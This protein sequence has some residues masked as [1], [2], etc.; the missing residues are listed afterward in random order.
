[1]D[2][3]PPRRDI[4]TCMKEVWDKNHPNLFELVNKNYTSL[5]HVV[6][7]YSV[8]FNKLNRLKDP[9]NWS[10]PIHQIQDYSKMDNTYSKIERELK[11]GFNAVPFELRSLKIDHQK[12]EITLEYFDH[13]LRKTVI[14]DFIKKIKNGFVL[15]DFD[16]KGEPLRFSKIIEHIMHDINP[17]WIKNVVDYCEECKVI[18]ENNEI[19][20]RLNE[21]A[22]SINRERGFKY[23][24]YFKIIDKMKMFF[25]ITFA[26]G[27]K[28][29]FD[30]DN[31]G[32]YYVVSSDNKIMFKVKSGEKF[33]ESINSIL[34]DKCRVN[35]SS[36]PSW[37]LKADLFN[38][39]DSFE[40]DFKSIE[41]ELNNMIN[42]YKRYYLNLEEIRLSEF[43]I[44]NYAM[45]DNIDFA[46]PKQKETKID[47]SN[48]II[49]NKEPVKKK[50]TTY[51]NSVDIE[52]IKNKVYQTLLKVEGKITKKIELP[53]AVLFSKDADGVKVIDERFIPF[54]KDLNLSKNDFTDVSVIDIDFSNCN[55]KLLDPQTVY[56]KDMSGV[57]FNT[58]PF[59]KNVS[60]KGVKLSDAIIIVDDDIDIN[61]NGAYGS[62]NTFININNNQIRLYTKGSR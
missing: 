31:I 41:E 30:K 44:N 36:I 24:E 5:N 9:K 42:K 50:N 32:N 27:E 10:E 40:E 51:N 20:K 53:N 12:D 38:D 25:P 48:V 7:I 43:P 2:I 45:L 13:R 54:L 62:P 34:F 52:T 16:N 47:T 11:K 23:I 33:D 29:V 14:T 6:G 28:I 55:P 18:D 56:N 57:K 26:N 59:N 60:F 49:A 61:F 1:M 19:A 37:L 58:I 46:E 3:N 22:K 15:S 21:R 35:D 39:L 17:Y 8:F 4:K